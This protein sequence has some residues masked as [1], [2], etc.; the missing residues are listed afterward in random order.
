MS[1]RPRRTA[2]ARTTAA[3][4]SPRQKSRASSDREVNL[5]EFPKT[6][7]LA[8]MRA[9]EA[10]MRYFR[11]TLRDCDLTEQQWRVLRT[12]AHYGPLEATELARL[13]I[14]LLPSLSRILRDLESRGLI[15][16]TAVETDL[17]RSAIRI[18]RQGLATIDVVAPSSERGNAEIAKRFGEQRLK[19]L[20][21][22]LRQLEQSLA[23]APLPAELLTGSANGL[24]AR[25]RRQKSG[26]AKS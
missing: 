8:L 24:R 18:S 4:A 6:L 13:A 26:S 10:V 21:E 23:V 25:R 2:R 22:M 17:R 7:P 16:R 12:L 3:A 5:V 20:H 15:A 14:L 1:V 11:P 19:A 9:R